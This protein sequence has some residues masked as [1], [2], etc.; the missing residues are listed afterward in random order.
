MK[1]LLSAAIFLCTFTYGNARAEILK[2]DVD[3]GVITF[4]SMNG[5]DSLVLNRVVQRMLEPTL[6]QQPF[7]AVHI[8]KVGQD[9]TDGPNLRLNTT[10]MRVRGYLE[11]CDMPPPSKEADFIERF[12]LFI[13]SLTLEEARAVRYQE[14][15]RFD[16][17]RKQR[18][19]CS[20]NF[21]EDGVCWVNVTINSPL[22]PERE[23]VYAVSL[24]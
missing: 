18:A 14:E 11:K 5:G 1:S 22:K 17:E 16:V 3:P 4:S 13:A 24:Y 2:F 15:A 8:A 6:P 21:E 20:V 19:E 9:L 7:R 12:G 23:R 10:Y